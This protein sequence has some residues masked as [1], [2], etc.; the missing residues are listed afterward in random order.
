MGLDL[1]KQLD[2]MVTTQTFIFLNFTESITHMFTKI[3]D[4]FSA[5]GL[6]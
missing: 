6:T 2:F 3:K 5:R 4:N 1:P